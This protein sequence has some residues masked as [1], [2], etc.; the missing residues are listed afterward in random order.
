MHIELNSMSKNR[1][2]DVFFKSVGFPIQQFNEIKKEKKFEFVRKIDSKSEEDFCHRRT[3]SLY[4][5][6]VVKE[7]D[8]VILDVAN[9]RHAGP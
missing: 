7:E 5:F 3:S 1:M 8:V 4:F 2:S 9:F 6:F